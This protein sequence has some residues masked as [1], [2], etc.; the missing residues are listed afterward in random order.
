MAWTPLVT[1]I[2]YV[3]PEARDD[4][5][6]TVNVVLSV[7]FGAPPIWT[8]LTKLLLESWSVPLQTVFAVLT[9][10][11]EGFADLLKV[12]LIDVLR[13]CPVA[14]SAGAIVA[15]TNGVGTGVIV[16]VL[17]GC[18]LGVFVGVLAAVGV[19]VG[20][21]VGVF[22]GLAVGLMVGVFVGVLVGVTVG[23]LVGVDGVGFGVGQLPAR[24]YVRNA[25]EGAVVLQKS[26][27]KYGPVPCTPPV[28]ALR[29]PLTAP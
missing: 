11:V 26:C 27:V 19:F 18:L 23:V 16:G 9:V 15:T 2:L 28:S 1:R 4:R 22:V 13:G 24:V 5:G 29:T 8:H 25:F 20:V 21:L 10:T 3:V 14:P 17:V 6:E 12:T 7:V